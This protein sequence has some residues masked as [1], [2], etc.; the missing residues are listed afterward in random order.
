[1]NHDLLVDARMRTLS[2]LSGATMHE[3]RGAANSLALH[4]QLLSIE[5]S[6]DDTAARRRRSLAAVDDG[7]RRL[8]DIAEVF[9]RHAAMPDTRESEFD[10]ARVT[11]DAVALSRP[12]AA[13][14]R[15][16]VTIAP[17]PVTLPVLGRRDV[18]SQV[19]LDL[20]LGFLDRAPHG[21]SIDVRVGHGTGAVQT[22]LS[23]STPGATPDAAVVARAES[24]MEWAGGTLRLD[25]GSIVLQLPV[26]RPGESS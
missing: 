14:R 22:E 17:S 6:D 2:A 23:S 1:M 9:V 24:A 7:R 10:L 26:S 11:G 4:L 21:A 8:F 15:V 16:E 12:Y 25:D 3:L 5:P 13:H 18:V 19:V 20:L